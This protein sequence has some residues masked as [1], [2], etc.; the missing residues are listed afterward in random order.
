VVEAALAKAASASSPTIA[1]LAPDNRLWLVGGPNMGGK[2]DLPA[3]NALIVLLAQAGGYVPRKAPPSAWSTASSAGV[4]ASDNL[5]RG[6]S[7]F[8]VEMVENRGDPRPGHGA[9]FRHPRRGR[10]RHFDL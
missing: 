5:A 10:P 1:E 4:G 3:Q 9:Q 2:V 8:M 6:R 7:T